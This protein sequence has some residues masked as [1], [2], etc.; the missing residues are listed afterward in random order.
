MMVFRPTPRGG[1][2]QPPALP[3]R[4]PGGGCPNDHNNPERAGDC[5]CADLAAERAARY[6]DVC[7]WP[8]AEECH[9]SAKRCEQEGEGY[10]CKLHRVYVPAAW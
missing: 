5:P 8:G 3:R 4:R 2:G 7:G 10:G 9:A 6:V 1:V